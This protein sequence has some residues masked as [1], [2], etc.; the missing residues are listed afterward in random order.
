MLGASD[1]VLEGTRDGVL[2][3]SA[4]GLSLG[5]TDGEALSS[6]EGIILGS[7][8]GELR[9]ML[10][11]MDGFALS[12]VEGRELGSFVGSFDGTG[13]EVSGSCVGLGVGGIITDSKIYA[14]KLNDSSPV[15]CKSEI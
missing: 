14:M 1:G 2:E 8:D 11:C 3:G 6:D 10:R 13:D 5:P 12:G 7:T 9:M 15:S 4:L